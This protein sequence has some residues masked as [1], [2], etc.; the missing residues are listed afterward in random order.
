VN[1]SLDKLTNSS[2]STREAVRQNFEAIFD[3]HWNRVVTV[4]Y[5]MVGDWQ[6]AE[7]IGVE[8]FM[9][10]YNRRLDHLENIDG[11]LYRVATRMGLNAIRSR[12]N[13]HKYELEAGRTALESNHPE[14]PAE[15]VEKAESARAVRRVL[16]KIRPKYARLLALRYSGFSY[17]EIANTLKVS[18]NSVGTLLARAEK[19][20]AKKYRQTEGSE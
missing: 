11:W 2:L 13:R 1:V 19:T 9:R 14:K 12:K 18:P 3:V 7:D 6:E 17:R 8:V 5:R 20:F 10:L 15:A 4:V 16:A